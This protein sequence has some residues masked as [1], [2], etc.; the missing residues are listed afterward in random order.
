MYTGSLRMV[1]E[2]IC[3]VLYTY[4]EETPSILTNY[5]K[6]SQALYMLGRAGT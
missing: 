1:T 4:K 3:G 5:R 2:I 6:T